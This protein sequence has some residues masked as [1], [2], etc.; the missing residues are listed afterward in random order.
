MSYK[1][2][3][4]N[5]AGN[6][7]EIDY[8]NYTHRRY[9][10]F[11]KSEVFEFDTKWDVPI[12]PLSWVMVTKDGCPVYRG[13][14]NN[15]SAKGS[16][17]PITWDCLSLDEL[18]SQRFSAPQC[19]GSPAIVGEYEALTISDLLSSDAPSQDSGVNQ[20]IP[21]ALWM[22][23][24]FM[25][26]PSSENEYH[27]WYFPAWG[28]LSRAGNCDVYVGGKKCTDVSDDGG[29]SGV[30]DDHWQ[31]WRD[32]TDLYVYGYGDA[33]FGP[34]CLD[35]AFDYGLRLGD[36]DKSEDG[37]LAA[38]VI[39]IENYWDFI[40]AY[41]TSNGL[42]PRLRHSG[43]ITYLDASINSWGKGDSLCP[44]F[45]IHPNDYMSIE[46][47]SPV[48]TPPNVLIGLGGGEGVTR[49]R[50]ADANI[51][52]GPWIERLYEIPEGRLDPFG[53]MEAKVDM[54]WDRVS[55]DKF[56]KIDTRLDFLN[57]GDWVDLYISTI[58]H[59]NIQVAEIEQ[60][61]NSGLFKIKLG[62]LDATVQNAYLDQR[63][64][65]AISDLRAGQR[66]GENSTADLLGAGET[67][68]MSW[69]PAAASDRSTQRVEFSLG[70]SPSDTCIE[71]SL[72]VT[73]TITVN[74]TVVAILRNMPWGTETVFSKLPITDAC[75]LD[76]TLESLTVTVVDPTGTLSDP[77][78]MVGTVTGIGRYSQSPIV[79]MVPN[80][81]V[82]ADTEIRGS[83]TYLDRDIEP[84][85]LWGRTTV[86]LYNSDASSA[87][88]YYTL[89][90]VAAPA[91]DFKVTLVA[92]CCYGGYIIPYIMTHGIKYYSDTVHATNLKTTDYIKNPNTGSNWT[93]QELED[94]QVGMVMYA[95][96][97]GRAMDMVGSKCLC[98]VLR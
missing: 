27:G 5:A 97:T 79:T 10:D 93:Q 38:I 67:F 59:H 15:G 71:A 77:V 23:Q 7:N 14:I 47:S 32:D 42:Y 96:N 69:T 3:V 88:A 61:D 35:N 43:Q 80:S 65:D 29:A 94:L 75:K 46:R 54:E 63:E 34:V 18:V 24:S 2:Y 19:W 91:Y 84:E 31:F 82:F 17:S 76:G 8:L 4:S 64:S 70:I 48:E 81:V 72:S 9:R 22:A 87:E 90:N 1:I 39:G 53:T 13:A 37:L 78:N 62:G 30:D 28:T 55:A 95:P 41:L 49:A 92:H 66:F 68:N 56:F 98:V 83:Y 6:Y 52:V 40:V 57:P 73:Y 86:H 85:S 21:G 36:I 44:H 58:E 50:Y 51:S 16:K 60:S 12:S 89:S 20:Y 26:I 25:P 74:S 45:V 33:D 11:D